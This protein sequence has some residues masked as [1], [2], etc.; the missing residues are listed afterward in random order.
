MKRSDQSVITPILMENGSPMGYIQLS[1]G[2][3][4]G[5]EILNSVMW[6][7]IVSSAMAVLLAF[8]VGLW[9]SQRISAPVRALTD[10]AGRMYAGDLS[11]RVSYQGSDELGQLAGSF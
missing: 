8:A 3:A 4:Y 7:W 9:I 6:G 1:E 10:A 5:Q 11:A 2:P